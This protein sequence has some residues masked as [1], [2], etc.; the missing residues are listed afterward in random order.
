MTK[1]L[2]TAIEQL[3]SL[4]EAEQEFFARM[5]L[6]EMEA[7]DAQWDATTAKHAGKLDRFADEVI[8][9]DDRGECDPLDPETL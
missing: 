5:L 1:S 8:A 4:P 3:K 9:A 6:D 2:E 7:D